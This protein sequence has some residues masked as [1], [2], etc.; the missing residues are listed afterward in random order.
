MGAGVGALIEMGLRP[1]VLLRDGTQ[2]DSGIVH[3]RGFGTSTRSRALDQ[4]MPGRSTSWSVALSTTRPQSGGG[5]SGS[6]AGLCG[7]TLGPITTDP[8]RSL[9]AGGGDVAEFFGQIKQ[10]DASLIDDLSRGGH[11]DGSL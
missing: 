9:V 4:E 3:A 5:K 7:A 6:A 11:G 1:P 8:G 10:S 2:A